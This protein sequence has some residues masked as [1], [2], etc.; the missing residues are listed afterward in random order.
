MLLSGEDK[1]DPQFQP[2]IWAYIALLLNPFCLSSQQLA[3][4][5]MRKLEE[6]VIALYMAISLLLVFLP[7]S[8]TMDLDLSICF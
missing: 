3:T 1:K 6:A 5:K 7:L 4:R 2:S 8:L